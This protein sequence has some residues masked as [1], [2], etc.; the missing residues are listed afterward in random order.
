MIFLFNSDKLRNTFFLVVQLVAW[1]VWETGRL[2]ESE[3]FHYFL[4]VS[5]FDKT[6]WNCSRRNSWKYRFVWNYQL[7]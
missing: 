1:E 2:P 7:F 6:W 4:F 5:R 3:N